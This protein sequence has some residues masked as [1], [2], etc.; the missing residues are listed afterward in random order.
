V[1]AVGVLLV[2]WSGREKV[3]RRGVKLMRDEEVGREV[4]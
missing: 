1:V 2:G 4:G 3:G